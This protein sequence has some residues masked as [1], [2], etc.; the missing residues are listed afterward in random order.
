MLIRPDH[1]AFATPLARFKGVGPQTMARL[2]AEG[3]FTAGDILS[4]CPRFYQDRRRVAAITDLRPDEEALAEAVVVSARPGFSPRT[5]R[6][7]LECQVE[8][9]SGRLTLCWFNAPAYLLKSFYKGRR[10]RVFGRVRFTGRR[11][12]M[13]HPD[14][15]FLPEDEP[16]LSA[17]R[18]DPES[19]A[20]EF[21]VRPVYGPVGQLSSGQV[22]KFVVQA[23]S[24]LNG[25]P[26]LF[27]AAWLAAHGLEDYLDALRTLHSPPADF[28]GPVPRPAETRAYG[29]LVFFE[30]VF[31]RL[32]MLKARA[33]VMTTA[34]PRPRLKA[35]ERALASFWAALSFSPSP[36]QRRVSLE[37]TA[38]LSGRRP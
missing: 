1:P 20:S 2:A 32:L 38:D 12:E 19:S 5:R 4:I 9:D 25:G 10:L 16:T 36:E 24:F 18:S 14:L 37:I 28:Q 35:G 8:D 29:R 31:W 3:L 21:T 11:L 34:K 17:A 30:L 6:R 33:G 26:P 23:L 13:A 22:K 27:P 7:Y 15:E